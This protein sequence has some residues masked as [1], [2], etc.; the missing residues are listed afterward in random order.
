LSG[1]NRVCTSKM[2]IQ[3]PEE[4]KIW[5]LRCAALRFPALRLSPSC[6]QSSIAIQ[7]SRGVEFIGLRNSSD[8]EM[9]G[10]T[11]L[12]KSKIIPIDKLNLVAITMIR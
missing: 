1:L 12:N 6:H 8:I 3:G 5:P 7:Y 11:L 9:P 4:P 2:R 10:M